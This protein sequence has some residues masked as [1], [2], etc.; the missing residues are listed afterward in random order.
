M[1]TNWLARHSCSHDFMLAVTYAGAL[2]ITLLATTG[3]RVTE[4]CSLRKGRI[5]F[6]ALELRILGKGEK[7]RVVPLLPSTAERLR[8]YINRHPGSSLFVFPGGG[9]AGYAD[10]DNIEKT[11][12][13]ACFRAG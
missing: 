5:D 4:A 6:D 7:H 11:L 12:R 9:K 1:N 3:L 8:G 10:A 13:R 2:V